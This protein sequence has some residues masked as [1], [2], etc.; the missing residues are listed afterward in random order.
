MIRLKT[1]LYQYDPRLWENGLIYAY[2]V[3]L[4]Y[5]CC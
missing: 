4:F 1:V 2:I 3:G 5:E